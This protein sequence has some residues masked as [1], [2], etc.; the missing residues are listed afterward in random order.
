[1]GKLTKT[2]VCYQ[3]LYYCCDAPDKVF[4]WRDMDL[5][6]FDLGSNGML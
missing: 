4:V 1:M 5:G 2:E 6:T 3:G